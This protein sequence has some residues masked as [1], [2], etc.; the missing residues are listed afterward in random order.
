MKKLYSLFMVL[1]SGAAGY[2]LL[3]N[4]SSSMILFPSLTGLFGISTILTSIAANTCLPEQSMKTGSYRSVKGILMGWLSG[5][6]VGILPG[7]G[8]AQAGVLSSRLLRGEQKDFMVSLGGINTANMIFT[9]IALY[10]LGKVR[11]GAAW[12]ISQV[13]ETISLS[14]VYLMLLAAVFSC[15]FAAFL[16]LKVGRVYMK[17]STRINYKMMNLSVLIFLFLLI[18]CLT[19][20]H[21]LFVSV[22]CTAIGMCCV[23]LGVK[24]MYLM[25]FLMVPTI[26]YY[27]FA[28]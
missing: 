22:C 14:D 11:S 2:L 26:V 19:G 21:G 27:L 10:S 15:L 13:M 8:S 6:L 24:R 18:G 16:T 23:K 3:S 5:M 7:T 4:V 28:A 20:M 25:G 9:F 12:A 17:V 1:V